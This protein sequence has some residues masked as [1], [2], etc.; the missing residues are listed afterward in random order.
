MITYENLRNFC[1]S[2][3]KLITRPIKGICIEFFGLGLGDMIWE[4]SPRAIEL[5]K[6]GVIYIQPYLNPWAWMNKQAREITDKILN[7]L[8]AHYALK[9]VR[10]CSSGG[11]MGGL[12]S[13]V[14][15]RY[16][17]HNVVSVVANCPVC[18][19]PFHLTERPDLPH[20]L[21]S[22]FYDS[23]DFNAALEAH[24]PLHLVTSMPKIPYYIFHCSG[25]QAVNISAHSDKF[26]E[27][28]KKTHTVDYTIVP[29]RGHCDLTPEAWAKYD[30]CILSSFE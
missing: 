2:N 5:A 23:T 25:D 30:R 18:D 3:D 16:S 13:L 15:A 4:D 8:S 14:F 22:A 7:V 10:I 17:S 11:S 6:H 27:Q 19:L 9:N 21:Y 26:A 12:S 1:Y 24:S 28:L 29:Q 20:T